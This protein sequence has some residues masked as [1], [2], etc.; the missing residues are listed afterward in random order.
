[1]K[2]SKA[3]QAKIAR[4]EQ[5][6]DDLQIHHERAANIGFTAAHN[7]LCEVIAHIKTKLHQ[8]LAYA[9]SQG[10]DESAAVDD[11]I[12]HGHERIASWNA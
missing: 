2:I 4:F 5:Q 8:Q 12:A 9:I 7:E 1:M 6:A 10:K 11:A 3:N